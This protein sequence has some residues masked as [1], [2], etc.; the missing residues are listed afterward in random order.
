MEAAYG[1]EKSNMKTSTVTAWQG[2]WASFKRRFKAVSILNGTQEAMRVG[3]ALASKGAVPIETTK[4]EMDERNEKLE[5]QSERLAAMLLLSLEGTKGPQ[6]SLVINRYVGMEEND[7]LMWA[8]LI[9]HFE[10]SSREVRM[11]ALQ[12]EWEKSTLEAGEHPNELYG[13]LIAT[14]SKLKG[15]NA[16]YTREQL[17]IRFVTA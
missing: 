6:Q 16:G 14:S 5:Q 13:R 9:R 2:D 15:L 12:K 11:S 10:M 1:Y 8:D 4:V 7:I 17:M 3:E